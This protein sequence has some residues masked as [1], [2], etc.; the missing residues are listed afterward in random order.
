MTT[1]DECGNVSE[2]ITKQ[3]N[4][5]SLKPAIV[6][7]DINGAYYDTLASVT[8]TVTRANAAADPVITVKKNN[9]NISPAPQF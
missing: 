3:I 5:D 8:V 1:T 9:V 4:I 6:L 2:T 7:P